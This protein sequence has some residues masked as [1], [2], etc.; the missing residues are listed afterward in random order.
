MRV[1]LF[2]PAVGWRVHYVLVSPSM[3]ATI[4]SAFASSVL[5]VLWEPVAKPAMDAWF[6]SALGSGEGSLGYFNSTQGGL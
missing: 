6:T 5:Y 4:L 1:A 2:L 3:L